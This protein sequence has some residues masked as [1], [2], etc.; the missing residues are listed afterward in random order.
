MTVLTPDSIA[1]FQDV[2]RNAADQGGRVITCGSQSKTRVTDDTSTVVSTTNFADIV[3]HQAS[4][5]TITARAGTLVS[6]L[7]D[8]LAEAGQHLP[9]DPTFADLSLIHI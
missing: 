9:F 6:D 2:V 4:D 7:R 1:S 5:F 3:D 8:A